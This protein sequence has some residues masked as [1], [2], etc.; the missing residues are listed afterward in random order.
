MLSALL[1]P[2]WTPDTT[3]A[4]LPLTR[5]LERAEPIRALVLD[6][7]RT[8][9]PRRSIELPASAEQW[10]RHAASLMPLHLL[11]NNPSRRRI[12]R[13]ADHLGVPFTTAAGKPRRAALRRVLAELGLPPGQVALVGDRVFTDVLAGNRLGLFTVLVRPIAAN[14]E[15]CPHDQVQ[16]LE[17]RLSRWLG[18]LREG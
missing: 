10:L 6:V 16:A 8:L 15:P 2:D 3:L 5:L 1:T 12:G 7:D 4:H 11:S 18:A 14:G 17:V 13:V 9:L